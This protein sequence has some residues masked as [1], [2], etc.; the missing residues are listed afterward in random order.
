[1]AFSICKTGN[2]TLQLEIADKSLISKDAEGRIQQAR[3][4]FTAHFGLDPPSTCEA[5]Y[6][7]GTLTLERSVQP[8]QAKHHTSTSKAFMI[9]HAQ[10]ISRMTDSLT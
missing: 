9:T 10:A 5:A 8:R 4:A 6:Q 3:T 1:M 2:S 7:S